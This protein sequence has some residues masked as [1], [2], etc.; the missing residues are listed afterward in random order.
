M[1][2]Q[3]AQI[4]PETSTNS[5][6]SSTNSTYRRLAPKKLVPEP[7]GEVSESDKRNVPLWPQMLDAKAGLLLEEDEG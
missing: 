6:V 7:P 2:I 3:R 4:S 1:E 5:A